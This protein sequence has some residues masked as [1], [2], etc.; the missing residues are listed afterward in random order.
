MPGNSRQAWTRV[1]RRLHWWSAALIALTIPV[2][3]VMVATPTSQFLAK[4]LLY[5]S[6]KTIGIIVLLLAVIRLGLRTL[7][8]R[9]AWDADLPDWQRRAAA[10]MHAGLYALLVITP[11]LGYLTAATAAARVPTLFLG[12]IPVPHVIGPDEN[13]F[14]ALRQAHRTA[15]ILIAALAS[16]HASAAIHNHL[17]G[18]STLARM[19]RGGA[20]SGA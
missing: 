5:Q 14:A 17:R 10:A 2:G 6:H 11:V 20:A 1:Q 3:F 15:A 13:W 12:L 19:W 8:G 7:S 16:G 9:P 4:F 18:R